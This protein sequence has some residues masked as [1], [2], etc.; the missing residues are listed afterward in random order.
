MFCAQSTPNRN[1]WRDGPSRCDGKTPTKQASE[2]RAIGLVARTLGFAGK[3]IGSFPITLGQFGRNGSVD[4][5][6]LSPARLPLDTSALH[7]EHVLELLDFV[8]QFGCSLFVGNNASVY[9]GL[10]CVDLGEAGVGMMAAPANQWYARDKQR[11]L[12]AQ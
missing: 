1:G 5:R 7:L 8:P 2:A 10:P 3:P 11:P 6:N 12:M 4:P 9:G